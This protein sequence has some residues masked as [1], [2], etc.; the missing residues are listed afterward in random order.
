M[1]FWP[2]SPRACPLDAGR[3]DRRAAPPARRAHRRVRE[4]DARRG[5]RRRRTAA[6]SRCSSC[7]AT[8]GPSYCQEAARR[9]G[10]RVIK[11]ARV[12]DAAQV[13]ALRAYQTDFHLLDAHSRARAGRHRGELRLGARPAAP[14]HAAG[15]PVRR[16]DA[17]Q[18]RRRR[19]TAV[20]PFAVDTASGTEAEPGRKDPGQAEA[21]F[22]AVEAADH[23]AGM[24]APPLERR[25]GPYGGR[26]VPETLI[27]A[28]DE[29]EAAW[30]AARADPA[31]VARAR[32]AAARLRRPPDAALPRAPPL[33]ARGRRGV[34]EARGPH[35][36][37][38]AQDQQR[39]RPGA[40]RAAHG[41][42]ARD[43]RDRRGPARRGGRHRLRA[44]RARLRRLHGHR[45]H[46]PPGAERAAHAAARRRGAWA[47]TPARARSRRPCRR[48]SATGSRTS[49]RRTT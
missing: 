28:L 22:R 14:G 12:R 1:I 6:A 10:C 43:R 11:A 41:Q 33:G 8:R 21:F 44:A 24:S 20:R 30:S 17:G 18:R 29:L 40:A 9:T 45:G 37:R 26:Y 35:P 42:A 34:A 27:P 7:T 16:A 5:G 2:D 47:S 19:S 36:H 39:A 25:F 15:G 32:R 13:Q 4:R 48:R 49:S 3:G 31:F 46:A 38:L 23:V